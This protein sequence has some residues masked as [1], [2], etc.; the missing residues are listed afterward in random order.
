[1]KIQPNRQ[2]SNF[3]FNYPEELP[4]I[5]KKQ[6]IISAIKTKQVIIISG[7]TGSGKTTQLPKFCLEAGRGL[8]K[9]IGCTQPRRIAAITISERIANEM[10]EPL[11]KTVGYKIRFQDKL[12]K[13]TPIKIMTDGILLAEAQRDPHLHEY[14]TLIIDEAH[15]RSLNIDFILGHLR[16]L[17][18]RRKSLKVIITSA[19]LDTEKFSTA[20]NNAPVI[21][22]SGRTFPVELD[23]VTPEMLSEN[24][25]EMTHVDMADA[26]VNQLLTKHVRGDMLIFMPSEQDILETCELIES[27][28]YYNIQV[29]PLYA[30]MS[31]QDQVK[32]FLK[33]THQKIIVATN[34]AETSI[35]IPNIQIVIDSGLAR[36]S[37]YSPRTKTTSLPVQWISKSSADQRKGRAGRVSNGICIRLY[38]E[39]LY[40]SF[41]DYTPP[42]ITRANLAEVILRMVSL[43]LG[44]IEQFPFIDRPS[45]KSIQDGFET[46]VLLNAIEKNNSKNTH[47]T[48]QLTRIGRLMAKL[49]I[50]PRLSKILIEASYLGCLNQ[51]VVIASA[52]CI[53]DPREYPVEKIELAKQAHA[54]FSDP[55]SDFLTLY[56]IWHAY[57][58]HKT[59]QKSKSKV[60][61]FCKQHFL[62]I[63]RMREMED[64]HQQLCTIL[65]EANLMPESSDVLSLNT[66]DHSINSLHYQAIHKAIVSGHLPNIAFKK[67]KNIY[68]GTRSREI[69]IFPGSGLFNKANQ[70]IV[71]AE[72]IETNRIYARI[73]A[74]INSD[75]LEKIAKNQ[76][77]STYFNPYW[78]RKR[79]QV[80]AYEQVSLF[81]L[82][83]IPERKVSY[84]RINPETA[85]EIFIHQALIKADMDTP[86]AFLTHNQEII[87]TVKDYENR[88][89]RRDILVHENYL[90][91]FYQK[92]LSGIYDIHGLKHKIHQSGT[93]E[94]LRLTLDEVMN[95]SIESDVTG[96]FPTSISLGAYQLA[97][98]YAFQPGQP[99]DGVTVKI[100]ASYLGNFPFESIDWTIPGWYREMITLLLKGLPKT[101]RKQLAPL[102][103]T[104]ERILKEMPKQQTLLMSSLGKFIYERFGI[105]IPS[106][107]WSTN[108]L[109]EYLK[110]RYLIVDNEGKTL[111]SGRD[112]EILNHK[113]I[114]PKESDTE[115]DTF[116]KHYERSGITTWDFDDLPDQ[117]QFKQQ[118]FFP[119][120]QPEH[121][122]LCLRL[123]TNQQQ[124]MEIHAQGI[125]RLYQLYL[126]KDL[127]HIQRLLKLS[128]SSRKLARYVDDPDVFEKKIVEYLIQMLFKKNIR[129]H[130]M[131]VAHAEAMQ[132]LLTH[133]A[134][135]LLAHIEKILEA[136][137]EARSTIYSFELKQRTQPIFLEFCSML[138][139]ELDRLLPRDF[140]KCYQ[141]YQLSHIPRYL[142]AITIRAKR[143]FVSIE[144]DEKKWQKVKPFIE[145]YEGLL[146]I[147]SCSY[148]KQ[149]KIDEFFAMIEEYKVSVFAQELK[150]PF[151]IS[152]ARLREALLEIERLY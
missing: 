106:E 66:T 38:D 8:F 60:K 140:L 67:E 16:N 136:N 63:K 74:N 64:I 80:I 31:A 77:Q 57:I 87:K 102:A 48:Y 27:K 30:R 141:L 53:S 43:R 51:A 118:F 71:A 107:S 122:E 146:K 142:N 22:V 42:E 41:K 96:L 100:P 103:E 121:D 12:N 86:F 85:S 2:V 151:P 138:R 5:A 11:G 9:R 73:V 28:N 44:N 115:Q 59:T 40:E 130:D 45:T 39:R 69:M 25:E 65:D 23:Y 49:P 7:E 129:T 137:E 34:I 37:Y 61:Q 79:G 93:D 75:W 114:Q 98:E 10:Q 150:T 54:Q 99:E 14:D 84:A 104:T 120:I 125:A 50:D 124:A 144:K 123:L 127:K 70:W 149:K 15:E 47:E 117:L 126:A 81:G 148:E 92:H 35:T 134:Q 111:Y 133:H 110:M 88:L 139:Q 83:I 32:I 112:P 21:E 131:F 119:T 101:F 135:L 145:Q 116:I 20:F 62:S 52:L 56:N 91:E 132:P 24:D 13:D 105:H 90:L 108:T 19:T 17:I 68:L 58:T 72:I 95:F 76:C 94:F 36:L 3:N 113:L 6:D 26:V 29:Y 18:K 147:S 89:R 46:L 152:D 109:P 55:N 128:P 82:I 4:I 1:M 97:C 78:D 143:G 33:T